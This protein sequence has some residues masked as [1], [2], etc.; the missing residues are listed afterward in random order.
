MK[1]Q[2]CYRHFLCTRLRLLSDQVNKSYKSITCNFINANDYTIDTIRD[3]NSKEDKIDINGI[4]DNAYDALTNAIED[5]LHMNQQEKDLVVS[6]DRDGTVNLFNFEKFIL[7]ENTS[8][9][10]DIMIIIS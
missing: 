2:S 3:F 10:E 6:I 5:F 9:S 1:L 4:I 7:I 8:V